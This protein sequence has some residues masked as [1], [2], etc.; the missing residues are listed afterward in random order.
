MGENGSGVTPAPWVATGT[1]TSCRVFRPWDIPAS[2]PLEDAS[3]HPFVTTMASAVVQ[4][5]V[6]RHCAHSLSLCHAG[7][8]FGQPSSLGVGAGYP[9]GQPLSRLDNRYQRSED[10]EWPKHRILGGRSQPRAVAR[11]AGA[12]FAGCCPN[13]GSMRTA[14]RSWPWVAACL[15][16]RTERLTSRDLVTSSKSR[17]LAPLSPCCHPVGSRPATNQPASVGSTVTNSGLASS[18]STLSSPRWWSCSTTYAASTA[19]TPNADRSS[20]V[21]R[22]P[23]TN[24]T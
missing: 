21:T 2:S 22:R 19:R 8:R 3:T 11:N 10:A 7:Q 13:P 9:V 4:T 20:G 23:A 6:Q 16:A 17:F 14:P 12:E 15:T 5:V 18:R 1:G 24:W